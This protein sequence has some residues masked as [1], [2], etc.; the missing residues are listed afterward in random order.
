MLET[1]VPTSDTEAQHKEANDFAVSC[2]PRLDPDVTR[3]VNVQYGIAVLNAL[4]LVISVIFDSGSSVPSVIEYWPYESN[5]TPQPSFHDSPQMRYVGL[6]WAVLLVSVV[7][8]GIRGHK[9][10]GEA[11]AM[12]VLY[13]VKGREYANPLLCRAVGMGLCY[14]LA[15]IACRQRNV[16]VLVGAFL[17]AFLI[18]TSRSATLHHTRSN[19]YAP[20][21]DDVLIEARSIFMLTVVVAVVTVLGFLI[22]IGLALEQ[23]GARIQTRQI[24]SAGFVAG[25][26]FLEVFCR[27]FMTYLRMGFETKPSRQV[28]LLIFELVVEFLQVGLCCFAVCLM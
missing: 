6:A 4:L 3:I 28:R 25:F 18:E 23:V 20:I 27:P 16:F 7:Y 24:V 22:P 11:G 9:T 5:E 19:F 17:I 15:S 10:T 2:D 13:S 21:S 26:V 1:A 8:T 12:S 14:V